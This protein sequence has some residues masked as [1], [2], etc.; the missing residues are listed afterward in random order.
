MKCGTLILETNHL[1]HSNWPPEADLELTVEPQLTLKQDFLT[2][3]KLMGSNHRA[4]SLK[5]I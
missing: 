1:N 5:T 4:V 2:S 3:T